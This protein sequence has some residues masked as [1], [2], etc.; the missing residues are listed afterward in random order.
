[1]HT[2]QSSLDSQ[3]VL[4]LA[5]TQNSL[6][7]PAGSLS[8]KLESAVSAI[9][10][11]WDI[12][13]LPLMTV[14]EISFGE[15]EYLLSAMTQSPVSRQFEALLSDSA[16][17]A[18]LAILQARD[19]PLDIVQRLLFVEGAVYQHFI[20]GGDIPLAMLDTRSPLLL[21]TPLPPIP[22]DVETKFWA[23]WV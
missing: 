22:T 7:V 15:K 21:V 16:L 23:R 9:R 3:S 5:Q 13:S 14:N 8:F 1:M 12:F 20:M 17:S 4:Q 2:R 19:R 6:Q 18:R 11:P 10:G